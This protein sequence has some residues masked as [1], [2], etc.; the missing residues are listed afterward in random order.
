MPPRSLIEF[1]RPQKAPQGAFCLQI[2]KNA[3]C[4][5]SPAVMAGGDPLGGLVLRNLSFRSE[6]FFV[7]QAVVLA[8]VATILFVPGL[9]GGFILDDWPNIVQNAA[10]YIPAS[11]S[12]DD[13]LY[14]AY[15]FQ[16]G[17]S[18][19]PLS[20]LSFALDFW[21]AGIDPAAFKATNIFIHGV[22]ALVL[23]FLFR[24]IVLLLSWPPRRAAIAAL[25]MA[26]LWAVH[27]IQ[28]SSVLY[29]VQRMQT[30]GTLFLV[31]ALLAYV[32][33]RKHQMQGERS[34]QYGF[35]TLFFWVLAFA[36]KEDSAMLPAYTLALELTVL[37]FRAAKPTLADGIRKAYLLLVVTGALLYVLLVVPYFWHWEA[38]PGRTFSSLERLLTQGRVLAMYMGQI[39]L[40]LPG[41]FPFFYDDLLVS[42]SLLQPWTTL[43]ALILVSGLLLWALHWKVRR[44]LFSLGVLFFFLGHFVSSNVIGLELAFEHRNHFALIGVA[45]AL[46]DLVGLLVERF[47]FGA[48]G[49][50]FFLLVSMVSLGGAT[51]LRAYSWGDNLRLAQQ[52]LNFSPNSERAW[53]FLCNTYF[54]ISKKNSDGKA[55]DLAVETCKKG[56][57]RLPDS[58]VLMNNVVI[59]KTF[60]GS[61]TQGDWDE[62]LRRM[63]HVSVMS[64]Q[65]KGILWVTLTNAENDKYDNEPAVLRTIEIITSNSTLKPDEYLRVAAYIFNKTLEPIKAFAYLEKAVELSPVDDPAIHKMLQEL[66]EAG[67][68]DWVDRLVKVQNAKKTGVSG[69]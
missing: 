7:L 42:R 40:P 60:K 9:G 22:T 34:R 18:S 23:A 17:G 56:A 41:A 25:L 49:F 39:L 19:R 66:A 50:A 46:G 37:G 32:Q 16:P 3:C 48:R 26:F 69:S 21:R 2:V 35:L 29:V 67:R 38:Y 4:Y 36:A 65:N 64:V 31:L 12:V 14:A 53:A 27:P 68:Q 59:Y 6:R 30:L 44:P 58:A 62:F 61:V 45:L 20:M 13:L 11:P 55:L 8:V 33:M 5:A 28:V 1:A 15:S 24:E 52:L 54:E 63:E 57:D 47:G 51:Y 43:P 10:L